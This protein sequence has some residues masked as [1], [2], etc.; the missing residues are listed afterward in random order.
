MPQEATHRHHGHR[1]RMRERFLAGGAEGLADHELLEMMLYYA[2]PRRDTND[3]AHALIERFGSF[4]GVLDADVEQLCSGEGISR[5]SAVYLRMIAGGVRRYTAQKLEP[6]EKNPVFDTPEKIA[7]FMA[8]RYFGTTVERAYLL[9]FDNAMHMIDCFPVGDGSVS[10]IWISTRRLIE[11]AMQKGAAAAVLTHNHPGGLAVPS[12]DDMRLTRKLDEA[13]RLIEV[14]LLEHYVFSDRAFAP[15]MSKIR[16]Q[17]QE[18]Y[19]A[20]SLFDLLKVRLGE[21]HAMTNDPF[22]GYDITEE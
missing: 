8:P 13:F 1:A 4:A 12:G 5:E 21:L 2:I 6:G 15:I 17:S 14:P 20:S 19:A 10:G 18:N 9:L 22:E 16:A 3:P 7:A 11:R